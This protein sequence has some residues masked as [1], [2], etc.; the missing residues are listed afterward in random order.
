MA[1]TK[2]IGE[3]ILTADHIS[4]AFGGGV[5]LNGEWI[6]IDQFLQQRRKTTS[7]IGLCPDCYSKRATGAAATPHSHTQSVA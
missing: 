6:S 4:L 2:R 3:P 5:A 7:S 1:A